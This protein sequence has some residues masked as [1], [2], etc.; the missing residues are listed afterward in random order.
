MYQSAASV[1]STPH[2]PPP[3]HHLCL[4]AHASAAERGVTPPY[5]LWGTV[6]GVIAGKSV[7][8]CSS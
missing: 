7:S 6:Q 4:Q 3:R 2:Q 5:T 8:Q 1:P